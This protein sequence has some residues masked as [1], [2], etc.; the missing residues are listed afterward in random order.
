MKRITL[1]AILFGLGAIGAQAGN[2]VNNQV[3]KETNF[4]NAQWMGNDNTAGLSFKPI[5]IYKDLEIGLDYT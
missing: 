5:Q 4:R 3:L 1:I 2:V